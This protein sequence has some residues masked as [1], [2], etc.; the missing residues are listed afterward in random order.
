MSLCA[1]MVTIATESECDETNTGS[2]NFLLGVEYTTS[3]HTSL[4]KQATWPHITSKGHG[5][6]I[7]LCVCTKEIKKYLM[8]SS[9][10]AGYPYLHT[11]TRVCVES[12]FKKK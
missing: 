9:T 12:S 6:A 10:S 1:S 4:A 7:L 8:N 5:N 2:R 11:H 3:A